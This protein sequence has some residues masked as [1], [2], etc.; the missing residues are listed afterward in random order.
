MLSEV[1]KFYDENCFPGN[2]TIEQFNSYGKPIK[3]KYLQLI[4]NQIVDGMTILDAGCGTGLIP[5]LLALRNKKSN[6]IGLDFSNAIFYAQ[7]FAKSNN[8]ANVKFIHQDLVA[9]QPDR[10]FDIIICQGVLHH[11]PEYQIVLKKLLDSIDY[12]GKMILG[13][14]H[15]LGRIMKKFVSINY[16]SDLLYK[17]QELNPY[18][19]TFTYNQLKAITPGWEITEYVP[20]FVNSVGAAAFFNYRNG[21][22]VTYIL[23]RKK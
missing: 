7:D 13:L 2:Y 6:V 1:K 11:I 9:Y 10:K 23:E 14:Y 20:K 3:N 4:D 22:L 18:V 19:I 17:D 5:N 16:N 12:N 15:P 8:I 21:G